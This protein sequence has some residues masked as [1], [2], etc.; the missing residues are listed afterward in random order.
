MAK[1]LALALIVAGAIGTLAWLVN[2]NTAT[3][4]SESIRNE[5][6]YKQLTDSKRDLELRKNHEFRA[7]EAYG[8]GSAALALA[9]GAA[10]I[11]GL[12]L[13]IGKE[14]FNPE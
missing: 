10:V 4:I 5:S 8:G 3:K 13:L 11:G 7:N 6:Q 12:Y 1:K 2:L 9:E 14:Y